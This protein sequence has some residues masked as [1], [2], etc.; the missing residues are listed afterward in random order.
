MSLSL[1][2]ISLS[3][4]LQ[5]L[6]FKLLPVLL[7]SVLP[8]VPELMSFQGYSNATV[9][10]EIKTSSYLNFIQLKGLKVLLHRTEDSTA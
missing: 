6:L 7:H 10:L 4:F 3:S 5:F 8:G 9:V 2:M 1:Y